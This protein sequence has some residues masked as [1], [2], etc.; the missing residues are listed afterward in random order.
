MMKRPLSI[1]LAIL[2]FASVAFAKNAGDLLKQYLD[3][4]KEVAKTE[5]LALVEIVSV[6]TDATPEKNWKQTGTLRLKP[7]EVV[8]GELP[9][10]FSVR[11]YKSHS[12]GEGAWT[13]DYVVLE[14]GKTLLGFFNQWEKVWAVRGDGRTNVINNPEKIEQNLLARVQ[15]LFKTP[16]LPTPK[17]KTQNQV[18]DTARK[19]ADPQ[20]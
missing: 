20:H 9:K 6:E 8:G 17:E 5:T 1:V 16:L 2:A 18:P 14:K 10:E 7:V 12:E 19:L 11:F 15:V 3:N 4:P 13:W